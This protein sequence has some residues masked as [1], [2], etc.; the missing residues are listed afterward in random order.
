AIGEIGG[1]VDP[2]PFVGGQRP[3]FGERPC[4]WSPCRRLCPLPLG[5]A[6]RLRGVAV[7][8]SSANV[9]NL[10]AFRLS[11]TPFDDPLYSR[12]LDPDAARLEPQRH[13]VA[14]HVALEDGMDGRVVGYQA[15]KF[16]LD[17]SLADARSRPTP[18]SPLACP[19]SCTSGPVAI[20]CSS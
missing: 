8:D 13:D 18:P 19:S 2:D 5:K 10:I 16:L 9:H 1:H 7:K 15:L 3:H 14:G 11:K 12:F 17:R 20:R 4:A 6:G